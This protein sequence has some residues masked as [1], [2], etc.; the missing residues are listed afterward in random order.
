MQTA[1]PEQLLNHRPVIDRYLNET[2]HYLSSFS[3]TNIFAWQDF[4][5]FDLKIIHDCLC[6]F[7]QSP[8]GCFLYLPPLG[9]NVSPQVIDECFSLMEDVNQGN[10]VTRIENV[11]ERQ[12]AL[13]P[14]GVFK[15]FKKGYEYCYYKNDIISLCGNSYKSKRS[16]YNQFVNNHA[17]CYVPFEEDMA[18]ECL[19]LYRVWAKERKT[20]CR[21]DIYC[22]MV[23]ENEKVHELVL[24]YSRQLGLAGRV[25]KVDGKIKAYSFGFAINSN[26][27][28]ILF[29]IADLEIKGLPV[30]IFREFCRD[31]ALRAFKFINVMD[32]FELNN[33]RQ[34]KMSFH[35]CA[36]L[37][38][39]VVMKNNYLLRFS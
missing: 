28:C 36:M 27:F 18:E 3:F 37:R 22:E 19:D 15:H 2:P 17:H 31:P 7:A 16:S 8:T 32:D 11:N 4:F 25:V 21:D 13:F 29:E 33:I 20:M 26:M 35:P 30:Y 38:S 9:K 39:Y 1:P 14:E 24:R 5:R 23:R 10:G 34:T 12:L 6:L